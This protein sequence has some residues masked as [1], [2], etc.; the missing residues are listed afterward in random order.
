[1]ARFDK[2]RRR[3]LKGAGAALGMTALATQARHFGLVNA[4]AAERA[5]ARSAKGISS[6]Y[7]A[8]VCILLNGGNDG[9]NTIVPIHNDAWISNYAQYAAAR[10]SQGLA[11]PRGQLLPI[12]VPLHGNRTYGLHPSLG[13]VPQLGGINNGIHE[14]W[15]QGRLAAVVNMGNLVQPLLKSQYLNTPSLRPYQ[16]FSHSDQMQ[17]QQS[18]RSDMPIPIG[19]G[20]KIADR[21]NGAANPSGRVPMI[22]SIGGVQLFTLGQTTMP[23]SIGDAR[24]RL[25][26]A[27]MLYGV[28]GADQFSA[29]RATALS[30]LRNV[31]LDSELVRAASHIMDQA[32]AASSAL[33]SFEEVTVPFP[34]TNIG[35]QMK[36]VAR[37]IKKRGELN[38]NRQL[39][40]VELGGFDSHQNQLYG[41]TSQTSLLAQLSQAMRAFYDEM[42]AQNMLERVTQFT[43]SDFGRTLNPSGIGSG[44]GTDHGW[45]N[46]MLV[47]GGSVVGG[48]FYGSFRPDG[49][50]NIFPTLQQGGPDDVDIGSAPR[51]RWLPTTSV[52]Q[53]A[54]TLSRWF[55]LTGS[56]ITAVFPNIVN[57]P[58]SDLG[59][60]A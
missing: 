53:Y 55:G 28:N 20:G 11:I 2:E 25:N 47:L 49:S 42:S 18:S 51:G 7:R 57:F 19:W 35:N 50:G 23:L 56:D 44:V 22:T 33:N 46:H 26:E 45:G 16:L 30:E 40:F 39:F 34:N 37:L 58:T 8:L 24:T 41:Q 32:Q 4:L 48:E 31:D 54:G 52:E 14:L 3:F 9:N 5:E 21:K 27:L 15:E 17:Q 6:D 13:P 1:M 43:L 29:A 10:T 38:I 59:F 60:M 12:A 36:Q